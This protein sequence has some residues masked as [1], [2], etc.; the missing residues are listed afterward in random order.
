MNVKWTSFYMVDGV[1]WLV[2]DESNIEQEA[3]FYLADIASFT[4]DWLPEGGQMVMTMRDGET[5]TV[6]FPEGDMGEECRASKDQLHAA[7]KA[8]GRG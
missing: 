7:M 1:V 4:V 8:R 2:S 5:W 3:F 6:T